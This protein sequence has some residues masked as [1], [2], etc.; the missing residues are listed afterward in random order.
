MSSATELEGSSG[1]LTEDV[2]TQL[3]KAHSGLAAAVARV[4]D[5]RYISAANTTVS[6]T[7]YAVS[8]C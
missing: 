1:A 2:S 3:M 8:C 6:F 7:K 4:L 5:G